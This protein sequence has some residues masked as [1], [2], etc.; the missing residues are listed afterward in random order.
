MKSFT[1]IELTIGVVIFS[2]VLF[3]LGSLVSSLTATEFRGL[4]IQKLAG[5][6]RAALEI[7]GREVRLARKNGA[8]CTANGKTFEID[9]AGNNVTLKF[10]DFDGRCI[11]YIYDS[12]TQ[13]LNKQ[14]GAA[15]SELFLGGIIK[16]ASFSVTQLVGAQQPRL[17]ITTDVRANDPTSPLGALDI[18]IQTTLSEREINF[19]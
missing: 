17:T 16:I 14:I 12:P 18:Y 2:F 4:A 3:F 5:Q 7:I 6:T 9:T 11:T 19:Q 10:V 13:A 15:P 8:G 1:L